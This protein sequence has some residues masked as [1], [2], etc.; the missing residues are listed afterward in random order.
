MLFSLL[1]KTFQHK[2]LFETFI[3]RI[4][5]NFALWKANQMRSYS[6]AAM[7]SLRE[8]YIKGLSYFPV[9]NKK[10]L[11]EILAVMGA[12]KKVYLGQS[13]FALPPHGQPG[14]TYSQLSN[15]WWM[16]S[17]VSKGFDIAMKTGLIQTIPHNLYV[18]VKLT[19]LYCGLKIILV[20]PDPQ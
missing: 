19:S 7:A 11:N 12:H 13:L 17:S 4:T 2:T 6:N 3:Q 20:Y 16:L 15:L 8:L 18:S 1:S 5:Q 10:E 9:C 14:S